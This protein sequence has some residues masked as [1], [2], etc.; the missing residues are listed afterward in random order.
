MPSNACLAKPAWNEN[1]ASSSAAG[2]LLLITASFWLYAYQTEHL[3]YDQTTT[4]CRALVNQIFDKHHMP[5]GHRL[6]AQAARRKTGRHRPRRGQEQKEITEALDKNAKEWRPSLGIPQRGRQAVAKKLGFYQ[7][8]VL[9]QERLRRNDYERELFKDFTKSEDP[10]DEASR[11]RPNERHAA[12]L[13]GSPRS[14]KCID[15]H[16]SLPTKL[17]DNDVT[18]VNIQMSTKTIEDGVHLNRAVLMA[19]GA[20]DRPAHHGRQLPHRPLRHRQA[21]QAPQRSLR[22]HLRRAN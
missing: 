1:A 20:G 7:Y 12:L 14:E 13:R 6:G 17:A 4:T 19:T 10:K 2:I 15:C 18:V 16:N 21:G 11:L 8:E 9:R 22:R 5:Q 3:A